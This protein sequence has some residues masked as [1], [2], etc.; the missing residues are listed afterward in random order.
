MEPVGLSIHIC[1]MYVYN[2]LYTANWLAMACRVYIQW[3]GRYWKY[4]MV[5]WEWSIVGYSIYHMMDIGNVKGH[6]VYS[7]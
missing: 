6:M 4:G 5:A 2:L 3:G 7:I 1:I